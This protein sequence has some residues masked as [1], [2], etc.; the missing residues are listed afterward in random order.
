MA[1]NARKLLEIAENDQKWVDRAGKKLE[2]A[3]N[4]DVSW[5]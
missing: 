2:M 1:G 5:E 4:C 3:G